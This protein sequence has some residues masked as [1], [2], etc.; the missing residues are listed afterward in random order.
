MKKKLNRREFIAT[1]AAAC[2]AS[3]ATPRLA[4]ALASAQRTPRHEQ[5]RAATPK[6][7]ASFDTQAR[8]VLARMTLEEKIGQMTQAEQDA[9]HD[10]QDIDTYHLGS[11]LSGGGSDPKAGNSLQAWTDLY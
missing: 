4:A 8:E 11:L 5:A 9:L 6:P 2:A 1:S 7:L 10:V 3:M